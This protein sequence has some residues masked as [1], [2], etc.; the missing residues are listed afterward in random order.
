MTESPPRPERIDD[1]TME[2]AR[3]ATS[4]VGLV[5]RRVKLRRT[6]RDWNGLCPFHQEKTP[7]FKVSDEKGFFHCFGCGA[8]GDAIDWLQRAEG[9]GFREAVASLLGGDLPDA[10]HRFAP[11]QRAAARG[12]VEVVSSMTAAR[13]VFRTSGPARGEIVER[14]LEARGCDPGFAPLPGFPAIDQLRFHPRC[15]VGVWKVGA[16]PEDAWLTAPAM[17]A[18]IRDADGANW[19]VHLTFLSADGRSKAALPPVQGR[20]RPSRKI[21]GKVARNAVFLTPPEAMCASFEPGTNS[22]PCRETPLVVGEGLETS[23]SFA[24]ALGRPCRAVAALSLENLQGGVV[25]LRDGALPLWNL[26]ADPERPP[27]LL[28][29]GPA[30]S[31][32]TNPAAPGE[33]GGLGEV[34]I[35]VDADMKPLRDQRVQ[36]AKGERPVVADIDG[37]RRAEIC[38]AL[39]SQAWRRAGAT[40]VTAVR[41]RMG[42]DFN[43]QVRGI[44]A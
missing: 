24:Q 28:F 30:A 34:I 1:A 3:A 17:V 5:A 35:A 25:K 20:E 39:A 29:S 4:L 40:K 37:L 16:Q 36:L 42:L 23:W 31:P 9:L 11:E 43:D 8:H 44:A 15:P 38:A 21:F 2:R 33:E 19:G 13:W 26:R 27:F 18:P 32:H 12:P 14:W 10:R 7:S 41:P 6:G 22:Q